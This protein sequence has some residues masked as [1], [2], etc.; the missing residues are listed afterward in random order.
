MRAALR[1]ATLLGRV[2]ILPHTCAFTSSSGLVP[3]P[4]LTYR[5]RSGAIDADVLDDA[6]DADWCTVEWFFDMG[7]MAEHLGGAYREASYLEH[8]SSSAALAAIHAAPPMPPAY[9]EAA[10][11]W[12]LVPPPEGATIFTPA[13][14]QRGATD[15]ELLAWFGR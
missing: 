3:P 6:V 11:E 13:D 8:P 2:L 14:L 5:D 10:A 7:A 9:I 4:P 1:L 12:R 15:E